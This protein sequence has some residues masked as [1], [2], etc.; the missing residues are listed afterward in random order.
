MLVS[1]PE[2]QTSL[3]ELCVLMLR[4]FAC[5]VRFWQTTKAGFQPLMPHGDE[6]GWLLLDAIRRKD[7]A[8][9]TFRVVLIHE[10]KNAWDMEDD[11]EEEDE[12]IELVE[13]V[14]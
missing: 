2:Y 12:A 3:V 13:E 9:H 10:R 14:Q 7:K 6:E 11:S 5:T 8:C 4:W 1:K